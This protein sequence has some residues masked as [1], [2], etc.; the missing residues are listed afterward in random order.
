[1]FCAVYLFRESDEQSTKTRP[2]AVRVCPRTYFSDNA[3]MSHSIRNTSRFSRQASREQTRVRL[4]RRL[5]GRKG[6]LVAVRRVF[7]DCS[8][9]IVVVEARG[10]VFY[11]FYFM[12][13]RYWGFASAR[14]TELF[15]NE[16]NK[17]HKRKTTSCPRYKSRTER[18]GETTGFVSALSTPST[19]K[20]RGTHSYN[21]Q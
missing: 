11:I 2:L 4:S 17:K 21:A 18:L 1:M 8:P 20:S 6:L 14:R 16:N 9:E 10:A 7:G 13:R 5:S 12:R 19:R 15:E 3:E